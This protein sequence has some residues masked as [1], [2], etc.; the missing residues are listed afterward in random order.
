MGKIYSTLKNGRDDAASWFQFF[1]EE[2]NGSEKDI[3]VACLFLTRY[4]LDL[5]DLYRANQYID[6]I[7]HMDEGKMLQRELKSME[8]AKEMTEKQIDWL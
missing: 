1:I 4:F 8:K 7:L 2:E 5:K 3:E 6:E